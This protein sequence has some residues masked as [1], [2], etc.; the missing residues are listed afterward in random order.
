MTAIRRGTGRRGLGGVIRLLASAAAMN[1]GERR[2][3]AARGRLFCWFVGDEDVRWRGRFMD[4]L[5][6][7]L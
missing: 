7:P 5:F 4:M 3:A 6:S 1:G 2:F